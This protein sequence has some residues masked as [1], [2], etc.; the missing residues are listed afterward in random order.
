M[1]SFVKLSRN[2]S[3]IRHD[4]CPDG[5]SAINQEQHPN[6]LELRAYVASIRAAVEAVPGRSVDGVAYLSVAAR[7]LGLRHGL[8]D[9]RPRLSD[10]PDQ[11]STARELFR[12]GAD[13]PYFDALGITLRSGRLLSDH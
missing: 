11:S 12:M 7:G 1:R 4:E 5:S 13:R 3:G 6:P 2:R 9:R 10:Q 8:C